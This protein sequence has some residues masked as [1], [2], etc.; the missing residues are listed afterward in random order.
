MPAGWSR[1]R[2]SYV[3]GRRRGRGHMAETVEFGDIIAQVHKGADHRDREIET[4]TE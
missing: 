1:S 4:E 2:R 3:H